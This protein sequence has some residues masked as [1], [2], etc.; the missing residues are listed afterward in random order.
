MTK[1]DFTVT[2]SLSQR[3]CFSGRLKSALS[4]AECRFDEARTPPILVWRIWCEAKVIKT[5]LFS[6]NGTMRCHHIAKLTIS[7]SEDSVKYLAKSFDDLLDN[8]IVMNLVNASTC[9][10]FSWATTG[11]VD[12]FLTRV[13]SWAI[14][15]FWSILH[16]YVLSRKH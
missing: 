5:F 12:D 13:C 8:M 6:L 4:N 15:Q 1:M 11:C 10:Y 16:R 2:E 14:Q 7:S 9:A 3:I